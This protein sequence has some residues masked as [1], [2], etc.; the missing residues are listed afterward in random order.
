MANR[1]SILNSQV[2]VGTFKPKPILYFFF[3][4]NSSQGLLPRFAPIAERARS[5]NC[6]LT[7]IDGKNPQ[8]EQKAAESRV[9][10]A[11]ESV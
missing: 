9:L 11:A 3:P 2:N 10:R 6:G 1:F 5:E 8:V 4:P 7:E